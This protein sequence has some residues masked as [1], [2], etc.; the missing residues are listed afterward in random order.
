M[1]YVWYFNYRFMEQLFGTPIKCAKLL[2]ITSSEHT[3]RHTV[4][5][6]VR[7]DQIRVIQSF[8][9]CVGL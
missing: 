1:F 8:H 4:L 2:K 6:H 3:H 7:N 5:I 9:L